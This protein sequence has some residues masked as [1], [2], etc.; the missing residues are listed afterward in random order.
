MDLGKLD[1]ICIWDIQKMNV[2]LIMLMKLKFCSEAAIGR[3]V[4]GGEDLALDF[5]SAILWEL[6]TH[7]YPAILRADSALTSKILKHAFD[8]PLEHS[9]SL[10]TINRDNKGIKH[11]SPIRVARRSQKLCFLVQLKSQIQA[12]MVMNKD[13]NQSTGN[14]TSILHLVVNM[15]FEFFWGKVK[16]RCWRWW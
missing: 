13:R 12:I 5:I 1:P 10:S 9:T 14:E 16:F 2:K 4:R 15:S 11:T 7:S 6:P 8:I 3:V